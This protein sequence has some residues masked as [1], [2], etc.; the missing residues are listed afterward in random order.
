MSKK[1]SSNK[2]K[3]TDG[4]WTVDERDYEEHEVYRFR[5][6]DEAIEMAKYLRDKCTMR[7]WVNE[8]Y[9]SWSRGSKTIK[10]EYFEYDEDVKYLEMLREQ[11]RKK[12]DEQNQ[13]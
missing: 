9:L 5:T 6:K 7:P 3:R 13:T 10:I 11:Y 2:R 12:K 8:G 1:V 4:H